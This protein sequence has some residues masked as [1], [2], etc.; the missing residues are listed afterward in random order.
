M[1]AQPSNA[2]PRPALDLLNSRTMLVGGALALLLVAIL[3]LARFWP[4]S[5]SVE[6]PHY[7][8]LVQSDNWRL[9]RKQIHEKLSSGQVTEAVLADA[10]R[11]E[12]PARPQA[13]P[14]HCGETRP[15]RTC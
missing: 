6:P 15:L 13:A 2:V 4:S 11:I 7:P 8:E 1:S 5:P 3:A 14:K 10:L 9:W 12:P